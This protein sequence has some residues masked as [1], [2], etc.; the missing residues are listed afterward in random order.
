MISIADTGEGIPKENIE[1][2]FE[3]FFTT[4]ARGIGLGLSLC[5]KY[6]EAQGGRIYV[7]SEVDKGS[8]VTVQLPINPF[9][10]KKKNTAEK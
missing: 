9:L 1:K 2:A 6:V 3:P 8:T 5:K 10:L 4:K 7:E